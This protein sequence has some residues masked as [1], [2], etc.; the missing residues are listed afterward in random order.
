M[1]Q[2]IERAFADLL[3]TLKQLKWLSV[4]TET[5]KSGSRDYSLEITAGDDDPATSN[6]SDHQDV[7]YTFDLALI[8]TK[9]NTTPIQVK[10]NARAIERI[11]TADR[12]RGQNAQTTI[13][14]GWSK[15]SDE[16]REG[17][18]MSASVTIRILEK[19]DC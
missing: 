5:G 6:F 3:A 11:I 14:G 2:N 17:L 9:K 4:V 10:E 19:G 13:F 1:S 18:E 15:A 12:R 7:T 16:G 8:V